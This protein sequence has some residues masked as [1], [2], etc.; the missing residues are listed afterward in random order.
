[1]KEKVGAKGNVTK[2]V[3]KRANEQMRETEREREK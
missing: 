3:S 2:E 1:M